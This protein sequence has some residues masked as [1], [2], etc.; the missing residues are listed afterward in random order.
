MSPTTES[1]LE[2]F[3]RLLDARP[4]TPSKRWVLEN[5]PSHKDAEWAILRLRLG[6]AV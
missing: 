1:V 2:E 5:M 4:D 6:L 3:S